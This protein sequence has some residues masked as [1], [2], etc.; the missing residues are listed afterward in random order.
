[1]R[2]CRIC[3]SNVAEVAEDNTPVT[4]KKICYRCRRMQR[5]RKRVPQVEDMTK[6]CDNKNEL[7][8][9]TVKEDRLASAEEV[10]RHPTMH[11]IVWSGV[12]IGCL[13]DDED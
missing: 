3:S 10:R 13:R 2:L 11:E 4:L 8:E 5:L 12:C 9:Q 1:M 7:E 6:E